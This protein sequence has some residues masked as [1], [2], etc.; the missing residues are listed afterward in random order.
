MHCIAV[1]PPR[2]HSSRKKARL[3]CE[4]DDGTA[5]VYSLEGPEMHPPLKIHA[6]AGEDAAC[7]G[8]E[9]GPMWSVDAAALSAEDVAAHLE[10]LTCTPNKDKPKGFGVKPKTFRI[11]RVQNGRLYM[12]PWYGKLA[13]PN[14]VPAKVKT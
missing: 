13:I 5:H 2:M 7:F 3:E 6:E 10:D 12:P 11:G 8:L 1:S 14:A 9:A 4:D